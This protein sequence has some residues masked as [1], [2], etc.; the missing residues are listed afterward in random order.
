[1]K[2]NLVALVAGVVFGVGLALSGMTQ[3]GKVFGFLDLTGAF[4]ASLLLVMASA[5]AVLLLPQWIARRAR[6]PLLA[7]RFPNYGPTGI[8]GRCIG[9]AAIFGVGWALGGF[10]P[11]PAIA[12]LASGMTAALVF[13]PSMAAGMVAC[14]LWEASTRRAPRDESGSPAREV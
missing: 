7:E 4:D 10:C 2:A 11:G 1:V 13:V 8:D 3:P 12:S 6:A 5:I 9:G 14:R